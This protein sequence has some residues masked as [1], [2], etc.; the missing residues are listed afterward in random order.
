MEQTLKINKNILIV[1]FVLPLI[2]SFSRAT[3]TFICTHS[4][5]P[6]SVVAGTP[7]YDHA[8]QGLGG[9]MYVAGETP[10]I[11]WADLSTIPVGSH[12][13][14]AHFRIYCYEDVLSPG[15]WHVNRLVPGNAVWGADSCWNYLTSSTST[16]WVGGA[17]G[18]TIE[19][20]DTYAP[21]MGSATFNGVGWFDATLSNT[22]FA[23]MVNTGNYNVI[24]QSLTNTAGHFIGIAEGEGYDPRFLVDFETCTETP[25]QSA[26][27]TETATTTQTATRT[28]TA[29][30]TATATET[31]TATATCTCAPGG[32]CTLTYTNT[33][34]ATVTQTDTGTHTATRTETDTRTATET[35]TDTTTQTN[36]QTVTTIFTLGPATSRGKVI[37]QLVDRF[38]RAQEPMYAFGS[39][40]NLT[41]TAIVISGIHDFKIRVLWTTMSAYSG[42]IVAGLD[43]PTI[44]ITG[45]KAIS[46]MSFF[47]GKLYRNGRLQLPFPATGFGE[48]VRIRLPLGTAPWLGYT[49]CYIKE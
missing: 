33:R 49:I 36:T 16:P 14:S 38:G 29:T 39:A 6:V 28:A 41:D 15:E 21:S 19:G 48:P 10:S 23:T 17:T 26:T 13:V 25:A 9:A 11:L 5:C 35:R 46:N 45:K 40:T 2:T 31:A 43:S 47:G 4:S 30:A 12:I 42:G 27:A 20:T 1:F 44:T 18:C 32:S 7:N 8:L 22:Q 24:F 34:T 3:T 37:N